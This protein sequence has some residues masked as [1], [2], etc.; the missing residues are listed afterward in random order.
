MQLAGVFPGEP[1]EEGRVERRIDKLGESLDQLDIEG[2][3]RV[4]DRDH[5]SRLA[6]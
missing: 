4:A 1:P 5:R 3:A 6:R 2:R